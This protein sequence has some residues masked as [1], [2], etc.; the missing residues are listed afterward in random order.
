MSGSLGASIAAPAGHTCRT[1]RRFR[2]EAAFLE[3]ILPGLTA[4]SS[5]HA[6]V[7]LEDGVC[8]RH[9]VMVRATASCADHASV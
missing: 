4:M 9:D 8:I 7:R 2:N 1:C 5:A 3:A 6:D